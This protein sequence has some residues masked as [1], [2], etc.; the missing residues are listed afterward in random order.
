MADGW[1]VVSSDLLFVPF[2]QKGKRASATR[3]VVFMCVEV[4]VIRFELGIYVFQQ[5]LEELLI[6]LSSHAALDC[7]LKMHFI[8]R[9]NR[10][11]C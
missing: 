4:F 10:E 6:Y 11:I 9:T 8:P 5:T 2:R 3:F 7:F 1:D